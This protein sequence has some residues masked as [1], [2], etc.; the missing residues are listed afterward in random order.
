MAVRKLY[1]N[2]KTSQKHQKIKRKNKNKK[3]G[4]WNKR[5][6]EAIKNTTFCK[7]TILL[8]NQRH[9]YKWEK[10]KRQAKPTLKNKLLEA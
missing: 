9:K 8:F 5:T 2:Q 7:K 3:T 1:D 6:K 4:R 10:M